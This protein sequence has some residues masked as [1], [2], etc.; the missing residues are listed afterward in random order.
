MSRDRFAVHDGDKTSA[1]AGVK[2]MEETGKG[3]VGEKE[4]GGGRSDEDKPTSEGTYRQRATPKD[5]SSDMRRK[6]G[7]GGN[8]TSTLR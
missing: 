2:K 1:T 7:A 4:R 3:L 6:R 5:A 8:L